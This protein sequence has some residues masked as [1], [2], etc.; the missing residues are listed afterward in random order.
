MTKGLLGGGGEGDGEIRSPLCS[1]LALCC[2]RPTIHQSQE[3]LLGGNVCRECGGSWG[4][5]G[6]P[7]DQH[8]SL[9]SAC[10]DRRDSLAMIRAGVGA[11]GISNLGILRVGE[12]ALARTS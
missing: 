5:D 7:R 10:W 11:L 8:E 9:I 6:L 12:E 4:E 2:L 3:D 1:G